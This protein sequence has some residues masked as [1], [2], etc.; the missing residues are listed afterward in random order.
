MQLYI[1]IYLSI[2]YLSIYLYDGVIYYDFSDSFLELLRTDSFLS[3]FFF[4]LKKLFKDDFT[5]PVLL[6][7][8]GVE[9]RL[10]EAE[11]FSDPPVPPAGTVRSRLL[12]LLLLL[13]LLE[14]E[15]LSP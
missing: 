4:F 9:A 8:A 1:Y 6:S 7:F 10:V 14:R 2:T 13:F 12:G 15:G 11:L 3:F 5:V